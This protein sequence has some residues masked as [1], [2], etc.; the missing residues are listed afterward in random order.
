MRTRSKKS[1]YYISPHRYLE[2]YHFS[3]QYDEW[4]KELLESTE[5]PGKGERYLELDP[6]GEVATRR[7]LLKKRI[8][9]IEWCA[10]NS[11]AFIGGWILLA[12]TKGLSYSTLWSKY[13]IPC[14]KELYFNRYHKYFWLL[15]GKR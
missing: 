10:K 6:T 11:D 8:E 3:L 5:L 12:V 15:D 14:S 2:L 13:R 7:A 9:L 1:S 4:K